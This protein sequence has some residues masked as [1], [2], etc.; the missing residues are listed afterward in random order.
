MAINTFQR[1][2]KKH[3]RRR[4]KTLEHLAM[5]YLIAHTVNIL[6]TYELEQFDV[7]PL[8]KRI[9]FRFPALSEPSPTSPGM[10]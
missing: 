4:E 7:T 6:T 3:R 10:L 8:L 2:T 1:L 5:L 9:Y